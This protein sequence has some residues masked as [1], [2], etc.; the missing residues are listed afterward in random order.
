[1]NIYSYFDYVRELINK[2]GLSEEDAEIKAQKKFHIIDEEGDEDD[3]ND[4]E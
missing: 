2:E 1:M 4:G 3:D